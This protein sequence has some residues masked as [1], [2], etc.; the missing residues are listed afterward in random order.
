MAEAVL[1]IQAITGSIVVAIVGS[2]L[3]V[4]SMGFA[5]ILRRIK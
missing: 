1:M 5:V 2:I 4:F 3:L